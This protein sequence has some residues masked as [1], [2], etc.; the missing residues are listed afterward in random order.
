MKRHGTSQNE[1]FTLVELL[2]VIA[3]ITVLIAIL[4]PVL[5]RVRQQ[6]VDLQC[7]MNLKQ[8]GMAMALYTQQYGVFPTMLFLDA[9][10]INYGYAEAWPVQLRRML[11]GNQKLF[12]CPAQNSKCQWSADAPGPVVYAKEFH[13]QFGYEPGERLLINSGWNR[14]KGGGVGMFFSYGCNKEGVATRDYPNQYPTGRA[15]GVLLWN[16][17]YDGC[18]QHYRSRKVTSVKSA[19]EFV[20][21]GDTVADRA[22]DFDLRPEQK[23]DSWGEDGMFVSRGPANVHRG[24]ANILFCDGHVQWY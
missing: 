9:D 19:A 11:K 20:I 21:M 15:M 6:S 22:H 13:R 12:Y 2:V 5:V 10:T 16:D 23:M 7:Q 24:R 3:I 8:L 1:G 14:S 17:H 4:L 18:M